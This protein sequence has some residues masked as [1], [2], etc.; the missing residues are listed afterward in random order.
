MRTRFAELQRESA[1]AEVAAAALEAVY[2]ADVS[3]AARRVGA[4]AL[5]LHRKR[6]RAIPFACGRE[7]AALLPE[8]RLHA[9]AG[10]AHLPW[11]GDQVTVVPKP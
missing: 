4:P 11:L 10:D 9:L 6:D 5:V 2:A 8:G 1:T 3:E 7:L